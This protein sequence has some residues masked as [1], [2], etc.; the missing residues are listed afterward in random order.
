MTP[1]EILPNTMYSVILY[2][3]DCGFCSR[4]VIFV[5]Q[6]DPARKFRFAPLQSPLGKELLHS[7]GRPTEDLDTVVLLE[8]GRAFT[9]STAALMIAGR[10]QRPWPLARIFLIVPRRIRDWVYDLIAR[11]RHHLL[12][13]PDRCVMPSQLDGRMLEGEP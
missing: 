5:A 3:G 10:L 1:T 6:R 2:D 8:R 9:K 12:P 11:N 4:V 7:A 13:A